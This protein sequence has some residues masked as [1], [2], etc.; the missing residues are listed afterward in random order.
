MCIS[1]IFPSIKVK[2][3]HD[4]L[5]FCTYINVF[6]GLPTIR[7]YSN[8]SK[9]HKK[10]IKPAKPLILPSKPSALVS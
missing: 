5:A 4:C 6:T 9:S 1:A 10:Q 2:I 8:Q 3:F 7:K